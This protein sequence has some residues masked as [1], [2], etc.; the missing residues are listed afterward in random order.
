MPSPDVVLIIP[1][2]G[3]GTRLQSSLP[4]VLTPVG[5]KAMIDHLLTLYRRYVDRFLIVVHPSFEAA[6]RE[7]CDDAAPDLDVQYA[8]QNQPTG[9]LDAILLGTNAAGGAGRIWITWCDQIGVS[10]PTVETLGRLSEEQPESHIILPTARQQHPYIHLVRGL[11][12]QV[13]GVL[14]R[15]EGDSM[16]PVGES[17]M[18]LFSLSPESYF[19]WLPRFAQ[20]VSGAATTGERNFLPFVPWSSRRG[21]RVVTFPC[22]DELEALGINTPDDLRRME[23]HLAERGSR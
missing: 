5:G 11:D 21:H 8:A 7:H 4:K 15:R 16:P 20:D 19:E 9:M 14:Q 2:A 18:G 13:S 12:G 22:A 1:S 3:A 10:V 6:V 23:Q 17:D